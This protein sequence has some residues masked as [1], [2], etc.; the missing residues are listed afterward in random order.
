MVEKQ[1]KLINLRGLH[2][3]AASKLV[4]TASAFGS[5]ITV[6]KDGKEADAKSIMAVMMLAAAKDHQLTIKATGSD[7]EAAL[8]AVLALIEDKFG[9]EE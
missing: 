2:A 8:D 3:R 5:S 9:E 4:N 1:T 6:E 7:E